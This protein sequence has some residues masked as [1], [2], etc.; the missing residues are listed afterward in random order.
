MWRMWCSAWWPPLNLTKWCWAEA[1]SRSSKSCLRVAALATTPT[2][3]LED[4]ACGKKPLP[5]KRK[6]PDES[7]RH[8]SSTNNLIRRHR[9]LK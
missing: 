7:Y 5:G 4:F 1:T 2:H 3:F 8:I 6:D 9:R